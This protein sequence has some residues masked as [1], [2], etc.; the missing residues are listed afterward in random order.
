MDMPEPPEI[1]ADATMPMRGEVS[2]IIKVKDTETGTWVLLPDYLTQIIKREMSAY[3]KRTLRAQIQLE[4]A[5]G[6]K[7]VLR[8][9]R[10]LSQMRD[11][12]FA[13]CMWPM[14]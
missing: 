11:Q 10:E 7:Q 5:K 13:Q 3:A 4:Y 9:T 1:H 6:E 2:Y 8:L 12:H 14:F